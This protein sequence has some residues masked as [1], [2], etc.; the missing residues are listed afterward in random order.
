L[1][2]KADEL[3]SLLDKEVKNGRS[4]PGKPVS[5]DRTVSFLPA[6]IKLP[7]SGN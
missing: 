2:S 5:N 7:K 3:L 6:G 4:S 1:E